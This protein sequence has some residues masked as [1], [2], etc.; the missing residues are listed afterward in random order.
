MLFTMNSCSNLSLKFRIYVDIPVLCYCTHP[1][2]CS[3]ARR[4]GTRKAGSGG[5]G[6][7]HLSSALFP[8]AEA[9]ATVIGGGAAAIA[10][11]E[12]MHTQIVGSF[13][14]LLSLPTRNERGRIREG[15]GNS[16]ERGKES[17]ERILER[18]ER[19]NLGERKERISETEKRER[20][21]HII[22]LKEYER[23][24]VREA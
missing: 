16:R 24:S 9:V 8:A 21:R 10:A 19:E 22:K 17:E 11:A 14:G 23:V 13:S 2:A 12:V 18:E 20:R 1:M 6:G 4:C 15:I 3:R 5:D 7:G